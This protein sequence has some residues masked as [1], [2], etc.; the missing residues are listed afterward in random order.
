MCWLGKA[1]GFGG[2]TAIFRA[3]KLRRPVAGPTWFLSRFVDA[4]SI[5]VRRWGPGWARSPQLLGRE[6]GVWIL[7]ATWLA[8]PLATLLPLLHAI[9]R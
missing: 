2:K 1:F 8:V 7:T 3:V 4:S 6:V 9:F 5:A